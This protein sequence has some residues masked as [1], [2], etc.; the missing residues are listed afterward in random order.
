MKK[1]DKVTCAIEHRHP[2]LHGATDEY[3]N[4]VAK[5]KYDEDRGS[6]YLEGEHGNIGSRSVANLKLV[7]AFK[8]IEEQNIKV[9]TVFVTEAVAEK[10]INDLKKFREDDIPDTSVPP[11]KPQFLT[12]GW[13]PCDPET[14]KTI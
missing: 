7:E 3:P 4:G 9:D 6:A 12:E 5:L 14:G 10:V 1:G 8:K 13:T 2:C 11:I